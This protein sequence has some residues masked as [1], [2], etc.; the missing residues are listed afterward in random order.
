M[1]LGYVVYA[2]QNN[3]KIYCKINNG[4]EIGELHDV[5]APSPNN[6]DGLFWSSGNTRYENKTIE[7]ALGYTP[8]NTSNKS[9]DGTFTANSDTLY[10]SQKAVKTYADG[11]VT[12][13]LDDRG[14][15]DASG[16]VFPSSGGSG[17]AGAI[18]KGDLWYIS[19]GGT[20]GG[21]SVVVG[22]SIRALVDSPG[23]TSSNWSILNVGLGYVPENQANKGVANGYAS[24]DANGI[25]PA[26]QIKY[27]TLHRHGFNTTTIGSTAGARWTSFG[28]LI[29]LS[30]SAPFTSNPAYGL[31]QRL[32]VIPKTGIIKSA[33]ISYI[34]TSG[35]STQNHILTFRNNTTSTTNIVTSSF[36]IGASTSLPKTFI[37][38][39]LN[40]AVTENDIVHSVIE[41]PTIIGT[42]LS[43]V[44][45]TI[46]YVI[47]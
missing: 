44:S 32:A 15:F 40:I 27:K 38:S 2:H 17:T 9:I 31:A 13:L 20:L 29:M 47:E 23:Q 4:Y 6:N 5:Y 21:T 36:Q 12:G 28:S 14:N 24:L 11:L 42:V 10:P 34:L 7:Q 46:D 37:V 39:G 45:M 1:V 18:L 33:K 30:N 16:N 8:E 41:S 3:G 22:S 25:V 19:V 35:T 26:S 43:G